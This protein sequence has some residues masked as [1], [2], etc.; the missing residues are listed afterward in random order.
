MKVTMCVCTKTC[1]VNIYYKIYLAY[2]L[3]EFTLHP[4]PHTLAPPHFAPPY[5]ASHT[6]RTTLCT[7]R[8]APSHFAPYTLHPI[9]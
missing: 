8:F 7:P 6:L 5:F 2:R 1:R 4:P 9:L 3:I